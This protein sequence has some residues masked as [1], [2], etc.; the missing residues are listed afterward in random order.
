MKQ[1][2]GG[3]GGGGGARFN[4]LTILIFQVKKLE[5]LGFKAQ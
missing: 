3:L 1:Q 5:F 4:P 2:V